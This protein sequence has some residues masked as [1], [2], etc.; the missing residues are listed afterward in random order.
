MRRSGKN[1]K[2]VDASD[3]KADAGE[4]GAIESH[5]CSKCATRLQVLVDQDWIISLTRLWI[6]QQHAR[7]FFLDH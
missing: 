7:A 6:G 2:N 5:S 1:G 4:L 3:E